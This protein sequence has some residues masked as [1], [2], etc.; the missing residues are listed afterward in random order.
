MIEYYI[1]LYGR[2]KALN[3]HE[4]FFDNPVLKSVGR[5]KNHGIDNFLTEIHNGT[6]SKF[7][8]KILIQRPFSNT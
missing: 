7:N 2:N 8:S 3:V 4:Y 1:H 5:H 6:K